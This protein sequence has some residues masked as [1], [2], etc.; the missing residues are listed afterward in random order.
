M[1]ARGANLVVHD[2]LLGTTRRRFL[3]LRGLDLGRVALDLT[4]A[5]ET[6]V[7]LTHLELRGK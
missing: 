2:A 4:G 7:N 6:S 5:S 3:L 1:L